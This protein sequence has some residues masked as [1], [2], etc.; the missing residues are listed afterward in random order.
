MTKSTLENL[1]KIESSLMQ[2]K[3]K[4]P[5]DVLAYP[6]QLNDKMAGLGSNIS[7]SESKP[8]RNAYVVYEDL[9]IK[10]DA[11]IKKI[12]DIVDNDV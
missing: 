10:I 1:D 12:K 2:P 6:I 4:A 3:A 11:E 9:A 5:Q 7:S 8:T